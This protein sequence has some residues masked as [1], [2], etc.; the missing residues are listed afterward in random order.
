MPI[1]PSDDPNPRVFVSRPSVVTQPQRERERAWLTGLATL[2]FS[3]ITV[4][5]EDYS[6]NP[7]TALRHTVTKAHGALILGFRQ[8]RALRAVSL[9]DTPQEHDVDGW[10]ATPWNQIEGGLAI[11]AGLPVLIAPEDGIVEGVFARDTWGG[12]VRTAPIDL[13]TSNEA[14]TNPSVRSWEL[15][16]RR[17]A[18]L[19]VAT[20]KRTFPL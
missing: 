3:A 1:P 14:T 8:T 4:R 20:E 15:A 9:P 19:Q 5:R 10:L 12:E 16:V 7:W 18:G 11:M 17:R 6:P 2:G 13:W